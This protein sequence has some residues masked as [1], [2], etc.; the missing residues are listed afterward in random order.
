[1][2]ERHLQLD[3]DIATLAQIVDGLDRL[4][5]LMEQSRAGILARQRGYFT[6]DEEDRVRQ[7]LLAYRN[8]R[9]STYAIIERHRSYEDAEDPIEQLR[10]FIV[11]YAAALTV[12]AK[13]QKLIQAYRREPL[14]RRK[15]NEPEPA[16]GLETGFFDGILTRYTSLHNY[17]TMVHAE[18]YWR[19]HRRDVRRLGLTDEPGIGW[20][21]ELIRRQRPAVHRAFHRA[22]GDG[23]THRF[24][25]LRDV[26]LRPMDD[27]RYGLQAFACNAVSSLRA[28]V[29]PP[30]VDDE[31]LVQLRPRLRPG[32]LL[33]TR[34][35][36]NL[37]SALCPGFWVHVALYLG[38]PEDLYQMGIT[39][40]PIVRRHWEE[41]CSGAR[42]GSVVHA[43]SPRVVI[44]PLETVLDVDHVAVLRPRVEDA[45]RVH[46]ILESLRHM[47]KPYDFEFDFD[48]SQRIVCTGLVYRS[49]HG[50][51]PIAFS[52]V[53]H[54]GRFTLTPDELCEQA[55]GNP[56]DEI[57]RGASP[58]FDLAALILQAADGRPHLVPDALALASLRA[59]QGGMRPSRDLRL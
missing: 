49:Y 53:K 57:G 2:S 43:I 22:V 34:T 10:A 23:L 42:Y 32:D 56:G 37:T 40:Q 48:Q 29:A 41:I 36:R 27:A 20:L 52:L 26:L 35:E 13:S 19:R 11:G 25:I 8:Y 55:L 9:L 18:Q 3:A 15:L 1:M 16:F 59:I 47:G 45:I 17:A 14:V 24:K 39:D 21:C 38:H 46:A 6:P 54:L 31:I 5:N 4:E 28:P 7:L 44:C 51:G 30:C 50:R 12:Y 33:L 58:P